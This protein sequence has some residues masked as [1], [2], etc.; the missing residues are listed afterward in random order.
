[1]LVGQDQ[2]GGLSLE[3][4]LSCWKGELGRVPQQG[5]LGSQLVT[6]GD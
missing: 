1:M 6:Q 3:M 5:T 4:G 2:K